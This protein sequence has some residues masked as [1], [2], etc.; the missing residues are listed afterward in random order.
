MCKSSEN[1]QTGGGK[2]S[3]IE[4]KVK[5]LVE[6]IDKVKGGSLILFASADAEGD[7]DGKQSTTAACGKRPNRN[8]TMHVSPCKRNLLSV[9]KKKPTSPLNG[10][11]RWPAQR[12]TNISHFILPNA[13]I[14]ISTG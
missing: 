10:N 13:V 14:R 12:G 1:T 5:D 9:S 4:E 2:F 6:A 11:T 3:E 8:V 7:E